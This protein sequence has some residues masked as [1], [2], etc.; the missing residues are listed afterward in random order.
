[1]SLTPTVFIDGEIDETLV[2][3]SIDKVMAPAINKITLERRTGYRNGTQA[4]YDTGQLIDVPYVDLSDQPVRI[5]LLDQNDNED[6][7]SGV[8][9]DDSRK[10][11]GVDSENIVVS[12]N[13][14]TA[15]GYEYFLAK[16]KIVNSIEYKTGSYTTIKRALPFNLT[17]DS[18]ERVG[19]RYD[20]TAAYIFA[21]DYEASNIEWNGYSVVRYLLG[22]FAINH[23]LTFTLVADGTIQTALEKIK[24][25][26]EAEGKTY[27]DLLNEIINPR[28]GFC[29]YVN[30]DQVNG[31]QLIVKT[32]LA[33]SVDD[34]P[35]NDS[36]ISVILGDTH[37]YSNINLQKLNDSYYGKIRVKGGRNVFTNTFTIDQFNEAWTAQDK[38]DYNDENTTDDDRRELKKEGIFTKFHLKP[39]TDWLGTIGG[40]KAFPVLDVVNEILIPTQNQDIH[41]PLFR[42]L[43]NLAVR[44]D[45]QALQPFI[46]MTDTEDEEEQRLDN[47][48]S[49]SGISLYILADKAGFQLRPRL[50]HIIAG[51]EF[52]GDSDTDVIFDYKTFKVTLSYLTDE[53]LTMEYDVDPANDKVFE[54]SVPSLRMSV[55]LQGT[56]LPEETVA[57]TYFIENGTP[58]LKKIGELAKAWYG[59]KKSRLSWTYPDAEITETLGSLI[60]TATIGTEVANVETIVSR[61][62]YNFNIGENRGS[63]TSVSTEFQDIDLRLISGKSNA[64]TD[65]HS[66][67]ITSLKQ[68]TANIPNR[69]AIPGGGTG[70]AERPYAVASGNTYEFG[71]LISA[72][73]GTVIKA[74]TEDPGFNVK[75]PWGTN[76]PV[77]GLGDYRGFW[78]VVDK[79]YYL[80]PAQIFVECKEAHPDDGNITVFKIRYAKSVNALLLGD[81]AVANSVPA[82]SEVKVEGFTYATASADSRQYFNNGIFACSYDPIQNLFLIDHPLVG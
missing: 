32:I 62:T 12:T 11:S 64:V 72:A 30:L 78:D 65:K 69:P 48:K 73:D 71:A 33:V 51:D 74:F 77:S 26:W 10:I 40:V 18:G 27:W 56:V 45:K 23:G 24:G 15:Y 68:K 21:N 34:I 46:F 13:S 29:F 4:P 43:P 36:Q 67:E 7:L 80:T 31:L 47:P 61:V 81:S 19:N 5:H 9:I 76:I 50:P 20:T 14:Y 66:Q 3:V 59:R 6:E 53:Y 58:D 38:T 35:A 63:S 55:V 22:L 57:S 75:T 52:T 28:R 54:I 79:K 82:G 41:E 49:G 37:K 44:K 60:T 17:T 70:G 1:M 42:F 2:P 8:I 39:I 25:A 16:N